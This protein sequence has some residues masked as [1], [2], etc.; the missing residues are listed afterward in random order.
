MNQFNLFFV[1]YHRYFFANFCLQIIMLHKKGQGVS[2]DA[3]KS[4]LS[5]ALLGEIYYSHEIFLAI[6]ITS[7]CLTT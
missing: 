3:L 1:N 5:L 7:S 6:F 2:I 4:I